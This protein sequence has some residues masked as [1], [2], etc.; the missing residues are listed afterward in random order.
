MRSFSLSINLLKIQLWRWVAGHAATFLWK[1]CAAAPDRFGPST[2][3]GKVSLRAASFC[4]NFVNRATGEIDAGSDHD[5]RIAIALGARSVRATLVS[6][7][8]TVDRSAGRLHTF[9]RSALDGVPEI[10][11][12][13]LVAP[14]LSEITVRRPTALLRALQ[15]AGFADPR[16]AIVSPSDLTLLNAT[17]GLYACGDEPRVIAVARR[18]AR[19]L[20]VMWLLPIT[21]D[22]EL[23]AAHLRGEQGVWWDIIDRLVD[24]PSGTRIFVRSP[25]KPTAA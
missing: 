19:R 24:L 11:L 16:N 1:A 13:R 14:G 22:D 18:S 6:L 25:P 15:L 2:A 9:E 8:R 23:S 4:E 21:Q 17:H 5:A 12:S 20:I 7:S 10:E 3:F